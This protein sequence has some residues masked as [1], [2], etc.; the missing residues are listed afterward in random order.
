MRMPFVIPGNGRQLIPNKTIQAGLKINFKPK[1]AGAQAAKAAPA[2]PELKQETISA[3]VKSTN[4]SGPAR[5]DLEVDSVLAKELHD[6]G[7]DR[8]QSEFPETF[9]GN[10]PIKIM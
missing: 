1:K 10:I 7:E 5:Q 3:P 6:N 2:A 9:C 4:G 8:I